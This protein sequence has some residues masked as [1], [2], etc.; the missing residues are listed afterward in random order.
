MV[1][2]TFFV[3]AHKLSRNMRTRIIVI[4]VDLLLLLAVASVTGCLLALDLPDLGCV[5]VQRPSTGSE[6]LKLIAFISS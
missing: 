6:E 1:F 5:S 4:F 2:C 3:Y